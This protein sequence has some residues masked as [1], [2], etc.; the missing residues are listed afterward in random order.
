MLYY[1]GGDIMTKKVFFEWALV[2]VG[3]LMGIIGGQMIENDITKNV[4][5][6]KEKSEEDT[7]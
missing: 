6:K 2:I 7:D 3:G 5:E 4:I 1:E